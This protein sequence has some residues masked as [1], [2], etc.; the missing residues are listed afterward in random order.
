MTRSDVLAQIRDRTARVVTDLRTG[1][2][3]LDDLVELVRERQQLV[4]F[5]AETDEALT[6]G[7]RELAAEIGQL[8]RY[9]QH[10]C[11]ESQADIAARL[12]RRRPRPTA[13]PA[14]R[15]IHES[16]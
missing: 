10:W 13:A 15:I 11:S 12:V 3:T 7:V 6:P 8:D 14:A 16:A 4:E 1:S 2:A 5:L 9:V